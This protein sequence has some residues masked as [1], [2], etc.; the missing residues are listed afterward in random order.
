MLRARVAKRQLAPAATATEQARQ[1]SIAVLGRAVMAAG[2]YV[3]AHHLADRLSLLPAD[4]AFMGV[5]HQCQ[6]I[7][8]RLAANLHAN[9]RGLIARRDGRLTISIGAAVDGILDHSVDGGVVWTP[10]SRLAILALHRQI[11]IMLV[12]PEQSLAGAAEFQDFIEDQANG[13]LY[14]AVR[15]LLV[16]VAGLHKAH[17]RTDD[18]FAAAPPSAQSRRAGPRPPRNGQDRRRSLRSPTSRAPSGDHAWH[19]AARCSRDCAEPDG[20]TTAARKGA[21]CAPN[22]EGGPCQ[23][24]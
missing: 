15:V 5:R 20:P 19:I 4:I 17:R 8:A 13:L 14:A 21:P 10:P 11:E 23:R 7:A 24:S 18:E 22:D 3:A 2:G 1:Q 12:E 9:A 6:P 16:V